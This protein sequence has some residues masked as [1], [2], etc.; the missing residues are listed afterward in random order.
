MPRNVMKSPSNGAKNVGGI[1][2]I[3]VPRQITF[4]A[5]FLLLRLR[6]FFCFLLRLQKKRKPA[7]RRHTNTTR[8]AKQNRTGKTKNMQ[9]VD[10]VVKWLVE[11]S[12]VRSLNFRLVAWTISSSTHQ[13]YEVR[14]SEREAR[15]C[16][17][18]TFDLNCAFGSLTFSNSR[19]LVRISQSLSFFW[20]P[21]AWICVNPKKVN[22]TSPLD[23]LGMPRNPPLIS[24]RLRAYLHF[25]SEHLS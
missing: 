3:T 18:M 12:S 9:V 20:A 1:W 13:I 10:Q 2:S 8:E 23:A 7:T 5:T 25:W 17:A 15:D 19:N 14:A 6:C 4:C 24:P 11:I 21:L 16:S 22:S